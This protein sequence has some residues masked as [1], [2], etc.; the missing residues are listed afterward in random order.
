MAGPT[1]HSLWGRARATINAVDAKVMDIDNSSESVWLNNRL[2]SSLRTTTAR[3]H[4]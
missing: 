4:P 2:L 3:Y 1:N